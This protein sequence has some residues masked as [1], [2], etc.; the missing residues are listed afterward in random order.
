VAGLTPEDVFTRH[1][2]DIYRYLVRMSGRPDVA[3]DLSQDV[4]LRVVRALRNGGPIGHERGWIF[5][6]ARNVLADRG[7]EQRR[8]PS[9]PAAAPAT[10]ATQDLAF[11]LAEALA[12]LSESDRDVFLLKEVGGL[13]YEEISAACACTVEAVRSRLFRTRLSLR[14]SLADGR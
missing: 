7:R 3:D 9:G 1:Y 6:I 10:A 2:R 11:G 14:K 5:S 13:T 12:G 4:F 8:Q